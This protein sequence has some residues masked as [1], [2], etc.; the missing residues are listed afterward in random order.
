MDEPELAIEPTSEV[1]DNEGETWDLFPNL[2]SELQ[3]GVMQELDFT[4]LANA[5]STCKALAEQA[6]LLWQLATLR[7]YPGAKLVDGFSWRWVALSK[8]DITVRWLQRL[9]TI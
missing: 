9:L 5:I 4:T 7:T 3:W 6:P 1:I 8:Q 2:P